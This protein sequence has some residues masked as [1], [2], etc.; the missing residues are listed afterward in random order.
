MHGN[1]LSDNEAIADQLSHGLSGVR[2]LDFAALGGIE[3]D[4]ALTTADD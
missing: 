3:P 4:L 2:I 1:R